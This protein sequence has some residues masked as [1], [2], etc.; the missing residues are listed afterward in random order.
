M[1]SALR[2]YQ[3]LDDCLAATIA[4]DAGFN[5]LVRAEPA[6]CTIDTFSGRAARLANLRAFFQTTGDIFREVVEGRASQ[7]LSNLLLNDVPE[8]LGAKFHQRLP[9]EAWT[10]PLFF[11]TDESKNGQILEIQCPGSG[12]GDL[13]LLAAAYRTVV[14][15]AHL[16]N[17]RPAAAVADEIV[18]QCGKPSPCVLHLLDNSSNPASMRYLMAA[19]QPPLRYWGYDRGVRNG[20]CDFIRS[21][22]FF[23]LVAENLFLERLKDVAH[24]TVRFDLPPVLA[25]DQKLPLCLP[26]FEE[27]RDRF[28]DAIRDMLAYSYPVLENGF[29]DTDGAWVDIEAFSARPAN[30]RRY[31]LKYAGCDVSINWGSR[32]V[33]RLDDRKGVELLKSAAADAGRNR[34]WMIQPEVSEKETVSYFSRDSIDIV[35]QKLTAKYSCFYGPT[36]LI[37]IRTMHR[38]HYKVHGQPDTVIGLLVPSEE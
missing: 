6:L 19:T 37:G 14:G 8:G 21:H 17:F 23:G 5:E 32:S 28:S 4:G 9:A 11:R 18:T 36:S 25:F 2:F 7:T 15:A 3:T 30:R 31:F 22:S 20:K 34:F 24:G 35:S 16:D 29:R 27:T 13:E 1:T 38:A 10:I 12:W 26:F 33:F